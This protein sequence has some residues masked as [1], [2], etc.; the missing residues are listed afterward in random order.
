WFG[1]L[2]ETFPTPPPGAGVP[3]QLLAAAVKT[4]LCQ[5]GTIP[6]IYLPF[7][8]AITGL[9]RGLTA[10]QSWSR[11][12]ELYLPLYT[13]NIGFWTIPAQMVQFLFVDPAYQ[14][15][16]CC[17]AGLI[18]GVVLSQ[19]A[20]PLKTP[21][22]AAGEAGVPA[23]AQHHGDGGRRAAPLQPGGEL[24]IPVERPGPREDGIQSR[25]KRCS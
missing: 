24:S 5:F 21:E 12:R 7:F 22:Q 20:G 6:L 17:F 3:E 15:T 13:R 1:T 14:V 9:L 8:F 2:M 11:A 23:E 25:W 19:V 18:W 4:G 16:Y 10:E